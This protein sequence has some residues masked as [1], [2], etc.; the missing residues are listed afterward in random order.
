MPAT[1]I[2]NVT[3]VDGKGQ[4]TRDGVIVVADN[5]I[6][7]SGVGVPEIPKDALVLDGAGLSVM[8]GMFNCHFHSCYL[9]IGGTGLP[10][11]ME[12]P[13]GVLAIRGAFNLGLALECG[14]T[15]VISAGVPHAIDA[16][17]KQAMDEGLIKGPRMM[18]GSRDVSTTAHSQDMY[19]PWHWAPAEHPGVLRCDGPEEFRKGIRTEI[20]RGAE[21][22]KIFATPGHSVRGTYGTLELSIPELA[23]AVEAAHERGVKIRAHLANKHGIMTCVEL[24]FDIV[25]HGDELDEQCIELMVKK[26]AVLAPSCFFPHNV[27]PHRSGPHLELMMREMRAMLAM[28]PKAQAAGLKI[29]LGDD[30]GTVALEHGRYGEELAFYVEYAGVSPA[31]VITWATSNGAYAMG[32]SEDLGDLKMGML[33]DLIV[34]RGDPLDDIKLLGDPANVVAVMKDGRWAKNEMDGDMCL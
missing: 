2:R 10:I 19:F 31:D 5:R 9:G 23:A 12:A 34:V 3:L 26:G 24:G 6:V 15:S 33:A 30:Y 18:A 7:H 28:L 32:R 4:R 8:P 16:A 22:I 13:P 17:L 20:K 25:D 14:F 11:G 1:A 29:V 21:I 27:A